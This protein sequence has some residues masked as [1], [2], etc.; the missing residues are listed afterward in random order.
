MEYSFPYSP[1]LIAEKILSVGRRILLFGESGVGKST[2]AALLA[3]ELA[4]NN[5]QCLCIGADPG[6]PSFGIPGAVCLGE[7]KNDAWH[8]LKL[9]AL[10]TLNS[11]RFRLP[12]VSAVQRLTSDTEQ[13]TV[14]VDAPGIV[15]NVAGAEL[16]TGLAETVQA[17]TVLVLARDDKRLP[18]ENELTTIGCEIFFI[19]PSPLTHL[20]SKKKR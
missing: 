17:D 1:E 10:C 2:L 18:L 7:W 19:R 20:L 14:L 12:L 5:R 4:R 11:G 13:K 16:L 9:E 3:A 8:L 6:S 15:R